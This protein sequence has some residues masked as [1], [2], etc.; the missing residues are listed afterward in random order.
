MHKKNIQKITHNL[1]NK[2]FRINLIVSGINYIDNLNL[3]KNLKV[4]NFDFIYS[5]HFTK[6]TKNL[7]VNDKEILILESKDPG[8][9]LSH[10]KKCK[11]FKRLSLNWRSNLKI[12]SDYTFRIRSDLAFEILNNNNKIKKFNEELK[13]LLNILTRN[14]NSIIIPSKGSRKKYLSININRYH[15]G[16]FYFASSTK[17]YRNIFNKN[18]PYFISKFEG[19]DYIPEEIF[20]EC[21]KNYCEKNFNNKNLLGK[22]I[23]YKSFIFLPS[24]FRANSNIRQYFSDI[25]ND[26]NPTIINESIFKLIFHLFLNIISE[27]LG[28]FLFVKQKIFCLKGNFP[29]DQISN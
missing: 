25:A 24:R 18:L 29:N 19:K 11:H 3:I 23:F 16:D 22:I 7:F 12:K 17:I 8:E 27:I 5:F 1:K 4:K 10:I 15:F 13:K 20:G 2:K 14:E 9:Y 26:R 6:D 21:L 28:L